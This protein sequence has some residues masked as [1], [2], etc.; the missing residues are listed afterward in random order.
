MLR[1]GAQFSSK[2]SGRSPRERGFER[3][4]RELLRMLRTEARFYTKFQDAAHGSAIFDEESTNFSGCSARLRM[5]LQIFRTLRHRRSLYSDGTESVRNGA[6][7]RNGAS[8]LGPR[9]FS[10]LHP[11]LRPVRHVYMFLCVCLSMDLSP[12]ERHPNGATPMMR[13]AKPFRLRF[14]RLWPKAT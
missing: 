14:W 1:T 3:K 6:A 9:E 12:L 11:E 5:F 8:T 10:P 7:A 4:I 2:C 13:V